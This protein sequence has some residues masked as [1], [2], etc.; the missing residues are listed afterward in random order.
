MYDGKWDTKACGYGGYGKN[1]TNEYS[2][3]DSSI[4]TTNEYTDEPS[5]EETTDESGLITEETTE[6]TNPADE[7]TTEDARD[8]K[9]EFNI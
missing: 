3:E 5:T 7:Q 9:N 1:T 4:F 8:G 6:A 2:T